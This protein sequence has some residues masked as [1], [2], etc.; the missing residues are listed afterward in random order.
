MQDFLLLMHDDASSTVETQAWVR[1]LDGLRQAGRLQGGS[2][3]GGG[4]CM[5]KAPPIPPLTSSLTGFIRVSADDLSDA[6]RL[7]AGNPV[8]EAG[9]TVEIRE[10]PR[11]D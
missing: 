2:A 8:F 3:I 11:T 4:A 7:V 1:Y 9:G 6:C 5:R 10:L